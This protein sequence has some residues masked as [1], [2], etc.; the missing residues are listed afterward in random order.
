MRSRLITSFFFSLLSLAVS[1]Q[2]RSFTL[3]EARDYAVQHSYQVRNAELDVQIADRKVK[4]NIAQGFPQISARLDYTYFISLPTSLI[5]GEFFDRP[6][7]QIE[8]Q[9]GTENNLM[10]DV[11]LNQLIFDG[12]Y[13]IGLQYARIF[14]QLSE[15]NLLKTEQDVKDNVSQTYYTILISEEALR[16]LDSTLSILEKTR[17]EVGEMVKEGFMEE[18]DY[19]QLTLTVT[20]IRNS[21]NTMQRQKEIGH[22]LLKYQVGIPLEQEIG[23][24]ESL[25]ELILASS[26]ETLISAEFNYQDHIDYRLLISQEKMKVLALKNERSAYYPYFTGYLN[27]QQNAQREGFSFLSGGYPWFPTS[28]VGISMNLPIFSSG[29][30]LHRVNQAKIDLEKIQISKEQTSQGLTL[31]V[32]QARAEFSDALENYLRDKENIRLAVKI[33]G[34]AL[35]K[36]SEG[37]ITSAELTQQHR[38]FFESESKYFQTTLSLL[39]AKSRLDKALGKY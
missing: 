34:N 37:L 26:D 7:E 2:V 9:F 15:E 36:Y 13:F 39:S 23:L 21:I 31:S 1:A 3:K 19:D 30:R 14:R 16:V 5:P 17:Y 11:T 25:D 27:Y 20:D 4:E 38:Q 8:V 22:Q 18:T 32:N 12:R 28:S 10:A 6:G 33:Y 35:V 24:T 29:V